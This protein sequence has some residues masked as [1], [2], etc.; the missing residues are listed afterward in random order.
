MCDP[1]ETIEAGDLSPDLIGLARE[2]AEPELASGKLR[3]AVEKV[4]RE[5]II[6]TLAEY[7]GNLLQT[8]KVLGPT[9]KGLKDKMARYGIQAGE[10]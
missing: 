4:E 1:A 5:L 7:K 10:L 9:R 2:D 6:S 8:A 3:A